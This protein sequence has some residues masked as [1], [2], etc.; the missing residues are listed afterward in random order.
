MERGH[1]INQNKMP[2]L[3]EFIFRLQVID[4][5]LVSRST[6]TDLRSLAVDIEFSGFFEGD[7]GG[8]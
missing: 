8:E 5:L 2:P 7:V 1:R 4:L 3:D 6:R